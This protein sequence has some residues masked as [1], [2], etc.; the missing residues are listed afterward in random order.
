[1]EA[2]FSYENLSHQELTDRLKAAEAQLVLL[3]RNEFERERLDFPWKGN[4]GSWYWNV[5]QNRVTFNPAKVTN[6][7][8]LPDE[9]PENV[10]YEFFT[11]L[12]HPDD[13]DRVM[14]NMRRHLAGES[15]AYEVEYRIK[16]KDGQWKWYYDRGK[17]AQTDENGKPLLLNGIVFDI[18]NQ[19][20][21]EERLRV[22]AEQLKEENTD[23]DRFFS[24]IA[25]D[26]RNPVGYLSEILA[27]IIERL[28]S[29]SRDKLM[30]YLTVLKD[31]SERVYQLLENLLIW[32][33]HR[34]GKL[35]FE[36]RRI[37]LK[38]VIE[39]NLRLAA[40]TA[41]A[42]QLTLNGIPDIDM[43]VLCDEM[44]LNFILRNLL[45]NA[46]KFSHSGKTI[47][48]NAEVVGHEVVISVTDQGTGMLPETLDK[49]F[50]DE[51]IVSTAGTM[52][53]A[54]SG[55]GL[56]ISRSFVKKWKGRIWA[57]SEPD[58]GSVFSF[59]LPF[60]AFVA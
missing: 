28:D 25:H 14:N 13:F 49:L 54:G 29:M 55:L 52:G 44:M 48:L 18:S 60:V 37:Q 35:Q 57:T 31:D 24:I 40:I 51:Q 20:S 7:G 39:A 36:P 8:Y 33:R 38:P 15:P 58:K 3:A 43:Y 50:A 32:S 34:Q 47:Q 12:L 11:N 27:F 26:L 46:V 5:P 45:S 9:V 16:C 53:E 6:L 42:K 19:K 56:I 23:K 30:H 22:V 2:P 10:G 17:I 21:V 4:L 41:Q 1:M 59:T